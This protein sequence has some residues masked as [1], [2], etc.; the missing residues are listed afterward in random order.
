VS[1]PPPTPIALVNPQL[2]AADQ[3]SFRELCSA[4][5]AFK[6]AHAL[7]KKGRELAIREAF[8]F[9][10]RDLLD[11]VALATI[12]DVVPL[13][14]ENRILVSAG[15]IRLN[16]TTRPGLLALMEIAQITTQITGYEAGFQL[17]PRLNA[18]GRLENA[19][20]ALHLLLCKQIDEARAIARRLDGQNRE[21][22]RI[23]R[24]IFEQALARGKARENAS[25]DFVIV[26]GDSPWHIGV[27]GIV[28]SRM[29]Q[30]F[31]R[32]SIILGGDGENWRGSGRSIEGF[33][34]ASAL[35]QCS[36]L[37][38]SHG[39][40][41]MAAGVSLHPDKIDAFRLRIN[42][43][44]REAL[45]PEQLQPTLR[46]DAKADLGDLTLER[47]AELGKLQQTGLG[48]PPVHL[49]VTGL[50]FHRPPKRMGPEQ[51][52]AKFWVT[53]GAAIRESVWWN[54]GDATMPDGRFDLAFAPQAN[55]FNGTRSVQLKLLDWRPASSM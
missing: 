5:L 9:D 15:L 30:E 40:H 16:Q 41:A 45:K 27:V 20:E 19:Q 49:Y 1:I 11:L 2:A 50:S 36:D 22:Q 47:L 52:H 38:L 28:A 29:V 14:G 24:S 34:L 4:G 13:C 55:E 54:A 46:L 21:R 12:A 3:P 44:A 37:L 33:D 31:Y 43:L 10:L 35:R 18:A 26:D 32:P 48:N 7:M 17:A 51:Q 53:D 39:G 8:E 42:E 25:T 23:E 6:L